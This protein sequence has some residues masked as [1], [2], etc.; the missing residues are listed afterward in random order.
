MQFVQSMRNNRGTGMSTAIATSTVPNMSP[1]EVL[2]VYLEREKLDLFNVDNQ[3]LIICL[4]N[5]T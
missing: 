4:T 5:W 1:E 3:Q 2:T